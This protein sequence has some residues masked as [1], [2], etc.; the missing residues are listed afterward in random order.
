MS[1]LKKFNFRIA[2]ALTLIITCSKVNAQNFSDIIKEDSLQR[3]RVLKVREFT[4]YGIDFSHFNLVNGKKVG[5]EEE[6]SKYIPVWIS[7]LNK[8]FILND[9]LN[10]QSR[11]NFEDLQEV[12]QH[13]QH[14]KTDNWITYTRTPILI[15]SIRQIVNAINFSP[16]QHEIGLVVIVEA[17]VKDEESA[18]TNFVFFDTK[19]KEVLWRL[20]ILGFNK[21][22]GGMASRWANG[23]ESCYSGLAE[24][25]RKE[26]KK[27]K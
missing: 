16:A 17:F 13:L 10:Y 20:K 4:Y 9:K 27:F 2:V 1:F 15:D 26:S 21:S 19:T 14:S 8:N 24:Y 25:L 22:S 12:V 3:E 11:Y 23:L 7:L 5:T 6:V 18:Y